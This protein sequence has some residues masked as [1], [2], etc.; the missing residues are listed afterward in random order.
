MGNKLS[1]PLNNELMMFN[2]TISYRPSLPSDDY[3]E[4]MTFSPFLSRPYKNANI[5]TV[6]DSEDDH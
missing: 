6:S 1:I 5:V 2:Q 4:I 3:D